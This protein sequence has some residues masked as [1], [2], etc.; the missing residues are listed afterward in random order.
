MDRKYNRSYGAV[1]R[2]IPDDEEVGF[3]D[4]DDNFNHQILK[5]TTSN[6]FC[7]RKVSLYLIMAGI[8]GSVLFIWNPNMGTSS[9][10][11]LNL[12][13]DLVPTTTSSTITDG[14]TDSVTVIESAPVPSM[15][16]TVSPTR[17]TLVVRVTQRINYVSGPDVEKTTFQNAFTSAIALGIGIPEGNVEY[18][19]ME[20]A[21]DG[22]DITYTIMTTDSSADEIATSLKGLGVTYSIMENLASAGF[23][24][25][26]ASTETTVVEDISASPS[27]TPMPTIPITML[28]LTMVNLNDNFLR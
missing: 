23:A 3:T 21:G 27:P 28:R 4:E 8:I 6:Q 19:S 7:S 1:D 24:N 20:E 10:S 9:L 14:L 16:P 2:S 25:A 17:L 26:I 13:K 5:G 22:V 12:K 18:E 15:K 11:Y